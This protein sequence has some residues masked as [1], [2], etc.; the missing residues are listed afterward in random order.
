MIRNARDRLLS[1]IPSTL[2]DM[3][4]AMADWFQ[5]LTFTRVSKQIVN[6]SVVETRAPYSIMGVRQPL[7]AQA[8]AMKPEGQRAWKIEQIHAYPDVILNPDD[9]MIFNGIPYRVLDKIDYKEYGYVEYHITQ[10]FT[11]ST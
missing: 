4:D 8:L 11:V 10:D 9:I 5:V 2:P 3:Q 1:Q 7:S 6:F